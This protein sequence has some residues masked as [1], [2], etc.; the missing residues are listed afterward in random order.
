MPIIRWSNGHE[1][2]APT[3]QALLD[4]VRDTQWHPMSED[5]FRDAMA[6]RAYRWSHARVD[7]TLPPVEFFAALAD[8]RLIEIIPDDM[9]EQ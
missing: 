9:K 3:W 2:K 4:L 1:D 8:A 5:E 7:R 6:K